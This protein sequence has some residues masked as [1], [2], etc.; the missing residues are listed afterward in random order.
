MKFPK[1]SPTARGNST[2]SAADSSLYTERLAFKNHTTQGILVFIHGPECKGAGLQSVLIGNAPPHVLQ[3]RLS[4]PVYFDLISLIV[5]GAKQRQLHILPK[6]PAFHN[7]RQLSSN[8]ARAN[9]ETEHTSEWNKWWSTC[10]CPPKLPFCHHNTSVVSGCHIL[11]GSMR[12]ELPQKFRSHCIR[13]MLLADL[14]A[15]CLGGRERRP[16]SRQRQPGPLVIPT[17]RPLATKSRGKRVRAVNS[18]RTEQSANR[19]GQSRPAS[20]HEEQLVICVSSWAHLQ[21]TLSGS[22]QVPG[23]LSAPR[24]SQEGAEPKSQEAKR[25]SSQEARKTESQEARMRQPTN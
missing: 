18:Q 6:S 17:R 23:D 14:G 21:A 25:K 22:H 8:N 9:H 7:V 1:H 5:C 4:H 10:T 2:R 20:Q 13:T 11:P 15:L 24:S 19:A 16:A 3:R 12:P